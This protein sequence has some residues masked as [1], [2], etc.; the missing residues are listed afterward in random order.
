MTSPRVPARLRAGSRVS[1]G[2]GGG[3]V[4]LL[5]RSLSGV[6]LPRSSAFALAAG[7][8]YK[9]STLWVGLCLQSGNQSGFQD[10][11]PLLIS[12]RQFLIR[13]TDRSAPFS[14]L[15]LRDHREGEGAALSQSVTYSAFFPAVDHFFLCQKS[16]AGREL[17]LY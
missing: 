13:S 16:Q 10:M 17:F 7:F 8:G 5:C 2:T 3:C 1:C 14:P 9:S 4:L 15:S 12:Y 6:H 11:R